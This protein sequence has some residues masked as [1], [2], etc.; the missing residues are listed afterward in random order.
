MSGSCFDRGTR[1]V[2]QWLRKRM[3]DDLVQF[4]PDLSSIGVALI[5]ALAVAGC[6]CARDIGSARNLARPQMLAGRCRE[7][8]GEPRVEMVTEGI[9]VARGFDLANTTLI[10]T[11]AGNVIVDPGMDPDRARAA[12]A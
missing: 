6:V 1:Y 9:W 11:D 3:V 12:R 5:G 7:H 8:V 10:G 2:L 4:G